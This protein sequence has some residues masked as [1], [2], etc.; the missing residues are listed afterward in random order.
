MRT[1]L[2]EQDIGWDLEENV[3]DEEDDKR[4]VEA[5]IFGEV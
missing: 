2:L 5:V 1:Q 4:C 3:G